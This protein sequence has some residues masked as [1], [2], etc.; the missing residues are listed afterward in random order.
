[1]TNSVQTLMALSQLDDPT[2]KP[3]VELEPLWVA[4]M[5]QRFHECRGRV[6]ILDQL[7]ETAGIS[8]I[9]RL[10]DVVPLLFAHTVYKSYPDAFIDRGRW[11]RMNFWLNT[12]SKH[13]VENV[14]IEGIADA[15]EWIKRLHAAKHYVF[16]TSGTSGKNS[17]LNQ[18]ADD[19]A[20]ANRITTPKHIAPNSRPVFVLG[21]RK[22]PN[23]ASTIF[24]NLVTT[25]GRPGAI[26]FLS[27]E[28]LRITDLAKQAKM[29]RKI[30]EGTALPS[31]IT[32][33][34]R[35][36]AARRASGTNLLLGLIDAI[37]SHRHE[38]I[39]LIGM[40][41]QMYHVMIELR[42]RGLEAGCFHPD[43]LVITG[44]GSKGF[45]LPKDHVSEIM[46]FMG[47]D[48]AHFVQGYGMQEASSGALMIESGRY[49]FPGWIIPL[50]LDDKGERLV[51]RRE[52]KVTGRMAL[53]DVS[54]DGRWGGIISGDRVVMDYSASESGRSVPAVLE[55]ARYSELEGGDDKLTCAGT[56][57]SFV[58][59]AI[60]E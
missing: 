4:A 36:I 43:T 13:P 59:G 60:G 14:D 48:L 8:S 6:K 17:F 57:E 51:E 42:R 1:M 33:F 5:N 22:A 25:L 26:Y 41:P 18:S 40:T 20:F 10:E 21:P 11:D 19:V 53:F 44:G 38:P 39:I 30:G 46:T 2:S 28:E 12:L 45:D 16:A 54:I 34:E 52:G 56:I 27:D 9:N 29:R 58:R 50:L 35:Q 24:N 15:D 47:L 49:E 31:E 37:L 55:I 7:A 32:D 23:R 3:W